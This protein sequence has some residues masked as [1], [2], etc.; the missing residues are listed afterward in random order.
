MKIIIVSDTHDNL[1]NLKKLFLFAKKEKI[2]F[3][4]HCGDVCQGETLREIEENFEGVFL[5]LGNADLREDL[6]KSAKKTK[7]FE[8]TGEIEIN[9][10]K[11][12]FCHQFDFKNKDL[13]KFDFFFFGHSHWPFLRKEKNCYLANPGNLAGLFFKASFSILDT[14]KKKIYLKILEKI[15]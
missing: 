13:E 11:I 15:K 6:K 1:A 10:L 7:I 9:N 8:E 3:L 2:E 5:S 12:G 14:K 4:I